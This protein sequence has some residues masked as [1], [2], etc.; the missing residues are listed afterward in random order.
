MI[1][2]TL[3][4]VGDLIENVLDEQTAT[5]QLCYNCVKEYVEI[6]LWLFPAYVNDTDLCESLFTF[7]HVV[8]DVLKAQMGAEAVERA[9]LTFIDL[10]GKEQMARAVV[11]ESRAIEKF[12][13]IMEFI[14]KEPGST[15]RKFVPSTLTLCMEQIHPL[16]AD[17][18]IT[19]NE[20]RFKCSSSLCIPE[21]I[22]RHQS[23]TVQPSDGH[24][25][26]QLALL[27]QAVRRQIDH[28]SGPGGQGRGGAAQGRVPRSDAGLRADLHAPGHRR[29]QAESGG[30]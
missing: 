27:L 24:P 23:A 19:F 11:A 6:A 12:L 29:L 14:V 1:K 25:A 2:E 4:I 30:A 21:T 18:S 7:F 17:V 9:V 8:F 15:F 22:R 3:Q 20:V 10:F 13:G 28:E 5:K 16:V 26:P